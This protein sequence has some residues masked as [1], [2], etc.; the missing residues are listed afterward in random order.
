MLTRKSKNVTQI[1]QKCIKEY[2]LHFIL[3]QIT[4]VTKKFNKILNSMNLIIYLNFFVL[5]IYKLLTL[6]L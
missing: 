2:I 6:I 3:I 5:A 4:C 1:Y